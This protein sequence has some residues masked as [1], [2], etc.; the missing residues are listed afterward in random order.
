M[1]KPTLT[2]LGKFFEAVEAIKRSYC[3]VTGHGIHTP[4]WYVSM[5]VGMP[6]LLWLRQNHYIT[7]HV[8]GEKKLGGGKW[9]ADSDVAIFYEQKIPKWR[10]HDYY[11]LKRVYEDL[12]AEE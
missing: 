10:G 5:G 7:W 4:E 9:Q 8:K 1:E 3:G 2:E 6:T 11:T 12:K